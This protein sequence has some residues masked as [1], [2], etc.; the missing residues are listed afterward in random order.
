[1]SGGT[2]V[3]VTRHRDAFE[4]RRLK[5]LGRSRRC[6]RAELL[7]VLPNGSKRVIPVAWTDDGGHHPRRTAVQ[8]VQL[9]LMPDQVP[10][11]TPV[12]IAQLPEAEAGA[13]VRQ[14]ARL[15]ARTASAPVPGTE[16]GDG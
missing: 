16:A 8:L 9:S 11:P 13:T 12:V 7:V 3:T 6:G 5:V 14:L 4:G 1:M 2:E 15:I 10:A